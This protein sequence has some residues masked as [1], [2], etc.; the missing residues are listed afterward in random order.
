VVAKVFS[1]LRQ[2]GFRDA[3]VRPVL[4]ELR[5]GKE[6]PAPSASW[7]LREALTRLGPRTTCVHC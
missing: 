5:A 1:A 6:S 4:A 7:L 2:L 3:E